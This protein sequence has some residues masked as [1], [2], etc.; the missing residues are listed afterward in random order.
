MDNQNASAGKPGLTT[1]NN[2]T[3]IKLVNVSRPVSTGYFIKKYRKFMKLNIYQ[4]QR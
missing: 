3:I 1:I 2:R 4:I